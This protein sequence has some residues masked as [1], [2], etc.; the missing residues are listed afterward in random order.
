[1]VDCNIRM[2]LQDSAKDSLGTIRRSCDGEGD[3]AFCFVDSFTTTSQL[4]YSINIMKMM[5]DVSRDKVQKREE[6]I[7]AIWLPPSIVLCSRN[8]CEMF[9]TNAS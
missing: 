5:H 8:L 9:S 1:M 6:I 7:I 4:L 2:K 3:E